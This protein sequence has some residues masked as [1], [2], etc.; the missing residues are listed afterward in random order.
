MSYMFQYQHTNFHAFMTKCN[1][2]PFLTSRTKATRA[3]V[4]SLGKITRRTAN[5]EVLIKLAIIYEL[6][7]INAIVTFKRG[8]ADDA[9]DT[10]LF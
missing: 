5:R 10:R 1:I 8:D 4:L 6:L 3:Y 2:F 7:S 9:L